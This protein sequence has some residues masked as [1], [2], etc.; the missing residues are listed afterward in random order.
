MELTSFKFLKLFYFPL[1]LS[2]FLVEATIEPIESIVFKIFPESDVK[3][4]IDFLR[5]LF[6]ILPF[7]MQVSAP[8]EAE[9]WALIKFL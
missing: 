9:A 8:V 6:F 3:L 1:L 4:F 5:L 2:R 7:L